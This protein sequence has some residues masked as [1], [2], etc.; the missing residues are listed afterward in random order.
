MTDALSRWELEHQTAPSGAVACRLAGPIPELTELAT[1]HPE[2]EIW[3]EQQPGQAQLRYVA[4]RRQ[5]TTA[6]PYLI[7]S[8]DLAELRQALRPGPRQLEATPVTASASSSPRWAALLDGHRLRQAR[9]QRGLSQ[10]QLAAEAGISLT[11]MR[12][13][14]R[15]PAASCRSRTLGRLARALGEDPACL[16]PA[17][18]R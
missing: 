14:E 16:M 1:A 5:G 11:T 8:D 2:H 7:V 13:L 4:Q 10:E 9:R 17:T 12:R 3:A 6:Q 15:Q 18:R